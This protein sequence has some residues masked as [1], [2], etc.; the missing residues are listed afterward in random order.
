MADTAPEPVKSTQQLDL[1]A[2]QAEGYVSPLARVETVGPSESLVSEDGFIGVDPVYQNAANDT[3]MPLSSEEGPEKNL[4]D[5]LLTP[6]TEESIEGDK[7]EQL[8]TP[9]QGTPPTSLTLTENN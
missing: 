9:E 6:A 3:D 1:E 5:R 2:R 8:E 7:A 4:E